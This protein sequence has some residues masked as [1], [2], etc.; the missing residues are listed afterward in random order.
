[1]LI[2]RV[3][4]AVS[5]DSLVDGIWGEDPPSEVQTSLRSY[6]SNL[7]TGTGAAIE[8]SGGGYIL[9]AD[10]AA[11]DAFEFQRLTDEGTKSLSVDPD[12]A[13]EKL[14]EGLGLWRGKA[15][16]DLL[17]VEGL[18]SEIRRLEELRLSAVEARIDADLAL[19]RHQVLA[20]ELTALATEY[21]LREHF[22][23]QLMVAL[24]R[25]GRQSEALRAF[26]RT[27]DF[28]R[29]ELGVDPSP[30][31]QEL[32]LRIL[33]HD[34]DLLTVRDLVTEHVAFLFTDIAGSTELWETRSAAMR[35]ALARHD[36]ILTKAIDNAG[37]RLSNTPVT[38][39]L[40]PSPASEPLPTPQWTH[41]V[42]CRLRIGATSVSR[43]GWPS[44]WVRSMSGAATTSDRR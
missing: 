25:D 29:E 33:N 42:S 34:P 35:S 36:E 20:G 8:R 14:R 15:Y 2:S 7:R 23:S 9:N 38:E 24:Y 11:V 31:L 17:G 12:G 5:N 1:M 6:V 19:G 32:E 28:L 41:S 13:S 30:E 39:C 37:G 16:A 43:C 27:K 44:M 21:P 40:P 26:R 22:Q 18:Q 4:Q 3:G 10:P